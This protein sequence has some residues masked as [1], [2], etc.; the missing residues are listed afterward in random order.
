MSDTG[1]RCIPFVN[2]PTDASIASQ[3]YKDCGFVRLG[4]QQFDDL[5]HHLPSTCKRWIDGGTDGLGQTKL[6][7]TSFIDQFDNCSFVQSLDQFR[8]PATRP[9]A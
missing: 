8:A 3:F 2:T 1:S 6:A 9:A 4:L 7:R 5:N